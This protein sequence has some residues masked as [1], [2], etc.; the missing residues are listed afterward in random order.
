LNITFNITLHH[1]LS[2]GFVDMPD[3]LTTFGRQND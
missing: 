1:D 2:T 3:Y